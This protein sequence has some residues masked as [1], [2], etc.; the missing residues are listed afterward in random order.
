[1]FST[2]IRIRSFAVLGYPGAKIS[3]TTVHIGSNRAVSELTARI[4]QVMSAHGEFGQH[5]LESSARNFDNFASE[6]NGHSDLDLNDCV[7]ST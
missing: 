5:S 2:A 7:A 4:Q 3:L 1:M 6:H